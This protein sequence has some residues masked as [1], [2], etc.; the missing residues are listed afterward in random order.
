[1]FKKLSHFKDVLLNYY[2]AKMLNFV[3]YCGFVATCLCEYVGPTILIYLLLISLANQMVKCGLEQHFIGNI[4]I[5]E[6]PL[7]LLLLI[8]KLTVVISFS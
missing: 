2:M 3:N 1:M 6:V 5:Q 7:L 8:H 4:R